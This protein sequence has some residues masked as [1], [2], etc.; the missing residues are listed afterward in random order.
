MPRANQ[1]AGGKLVCALAGCGWRGTRPAHGWA[2]DPTNHRPPLAARSLSQTG[3]CRLCTAKRSSSWRRI[4]AAAG[5]AAGLT[6]CERTGAAHRR[7]LG[8]LPHGGHAPVSSGSATPQ[9]FPAHPPSPLVRF[10]MQATRATYTSRSKRAMTQT[11]S[12]RRSRRA[13]PPTAPASRRQGSRMTTAMWW[14]AASWGWR[15]IGNTLGPAMSWQRRRDCTACN[16]AQPHPPRRVTGTTSLGQILSAARRPPLPPP[17]EDE[18]DE[19]GLSDEETAS[20]DAAAG[21]SGGG[22]MDLLLHNNGGRA[23]AMAAAPTAAAG[24]SPA[25]GESSVR[26]GDSCHAPAAATPAVIQPGGG[27]LVGLAASDQWRPKRQCRQRSPSPPPRLVRTSSGPQP[28]VQLSAMPRRQSSSWCSGSRPCLRGCL[29]SSAPCPPPP[30]PR[31]L[32]CTLGRMAVRGCVRCVT[33]AA[34]CLAT[35]SWR[36]WLCGVPT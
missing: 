1:A 30:W 29:P 14:V 5:S 15:V 27:Q 7:L 11:A 20:P 28:G 34:A 16:P 22:F 36:S 31:L 8:R 13:A 17:Q 10:S 21:S 33:P 4:P 6:A 24:S 35:R 25:P 18:E 19:E 23:P 3:P 2:S 12:P 26:V 9:T 32:R